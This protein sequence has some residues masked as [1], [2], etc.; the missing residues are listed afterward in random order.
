MPRIDYDLGPKL[1]L[2]AW[3]EVDGERYV[4]TTYIGDENVRIFEVIG[5]QSVEVAV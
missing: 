5:D 2:C 3:I 1:T 4:N